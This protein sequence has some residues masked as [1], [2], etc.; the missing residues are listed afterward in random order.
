MNSASTA[1]RLTVCRI[2]DLA[3]LGLAARPAKDVL[4]IV[5]VD[6]ALGAVDPVW[7][8]LDRPVVSLKR[9]W[10]WAPLPSS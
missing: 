6:G 5:D 4:P 3:Q 8:P 9:M 1:T 7:L 10:N 2:R